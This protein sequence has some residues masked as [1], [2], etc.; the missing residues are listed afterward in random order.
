MSRKGKSFNDLELA[1]RV[2]TLALTSIEKYLK[3]DDDDEYKKALILRLAANTLPRLNEHSGPDGGAIP[4][5]LFDYVSNRN[6]NS[7]GEDTKVEQK[8]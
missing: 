8:N 6:N 5:P 1:G 7:N 3:R 4:L 2:R